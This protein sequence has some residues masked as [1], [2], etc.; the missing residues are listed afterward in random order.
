MLGD[1]G[2]WED[3]ALRSAGLAI[4]GLEAFGGEDESARLQA[5]AGDPLFREAVAWQN[6]AG[7]ANA[8]DKLGAATKPSRMRQREE[9]VASYWQRYCAKND[10]IGFFGPL[11]WGRVAADGAALTVR[12]GELVAAREVHF[13]GWAVQ[14]LAQALSDDLQVPL[15]PWP[16]R[17][18]R[19][20]LDGHEDEQLRARGLAAL[21]R[22]EDARQAAADAQ[23]ADALAAALARLDDVFVELT[24]Q[25]PTRHHGRAYGARTLVYI[26]CLRDAHVT[27]GPALVDELAPVLRLVFE[28]GR[29]YSGRVNA[30]ARELIAGVLPEDGR[31]PFGPVLGQVLP[32]LMMLPAPLEGAVAE[33]QERVAGVLADADPVTLGERASAAFA[34]HEPVWRSGVYQSAD[35]QIAAAS[36]DA[37]NAGDYLAVVAD[38]HA[39]D[40]PLLQGVFAHRHPDLQRLDAAFAADLGPAWPLLM[41]PWAP[42]MGV[43]TRGVPRLPADTVYV[44]LQPDAHAPLGCRTWR[45]GEL[46]VDGDDVVDASGELRVPTLDLFGLPIFV[47]GVRTFE[48]F[49]DSDHVDRLTIGRV[50]L[51]RETWN[52][53]A[54]EVPAD[55]AALGAWARARGMPRRVFVKTPEERKPF[56]V[57]LDS[58]VLARIA[59]RH[60]RKA[61]T[62]DP[63]QRVRFSEML[64]GPDECWLSDSA[65]RRY[66]SELR[67]VAVERSR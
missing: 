41:P 42:G 12:S 27:V 14:A 21:G 4:S 45:V 3:F 39:C 34:D 57:D 10:T 58:A 9:L 60:I 40:N 51:R 66:A 19:A 6:R 32:A 22:L 53:P 54:G 59:A 1:W 67:L 17:D 47:T 62:D 13:E 64:P 63:A 28:A 24:E 46:F 61:A 50:V 26:D 43:D 31:G 18:L 25:E 29:W 33:L 15:G 16:E 48:M 44:A 30:I 20:L 8:V 23:D 11:A 49:G 56:H 37:V 35:I 7:L 65:G 55:A 5:V 36:V 2:L 38:V 52:V